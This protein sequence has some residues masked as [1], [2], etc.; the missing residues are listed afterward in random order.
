LALI[1]PELGVIAEC[2]PDRIFHR[3]A[4]LALNYQIF[5]RLWPGQLP[6]TTWLDE[7]LPEVVSAREA[8]RRA[9]HASRSQNQ[10]KRAATPYSFIKL[11]EL[12]HTGSPPPDPAWPP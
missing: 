9:L 2:Q 5:Q 1:D 10:N 4:Q 7:E 6:N 3:K 8:L 11:A 12:T